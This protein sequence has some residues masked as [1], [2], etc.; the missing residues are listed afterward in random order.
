MVFLP[1]L[2]RPAPV[3]VHVSVASIEA[4]VP[5]KR[6]GSSA[7]AAR[8]V[9]SAHELEMGSALAEF[10]A[11]RLRAEG[12][13]KRPVIVALAPE[14]ISAKIL[15][16]PPLSPRDLHG[17]I[18]RR[19]AAL[20]DLEADEASFSAI[21]LDGEDAADR[22]WLVHATAK[23]P[24]TEFQSTLRSIGYPAKVVIPARTAPFLSSRCT[25]AAIDSG[26]TLVALFERDSCAIGLL[27]EGRIV[28]LSS[29][30]GGIGP[31]LSE[32][33]TARAFVQELRGVDA[34]WRRT[35][36]GDRVGAVLIGGA[37]SLVVEQLG[38]AIR[39]A[40]GDVEVKMLDAAVTSARQEDGALPV[41]SLEA[42]DA[43]NDDGLDPL[44]EATERAR[45]ALLGSLTSNRIGGLDLAVDLRPRGRNVLLVGS[46]SAVVFGTLAATLRMDLE[47]RA[48]QLAVEAQ[49]FEAAAADLEEL[50]GLERSVRGIESQVRTACDELQA[51]SSVGLPAMDLVDGVFGAF[52]GRTELLSISATGPSLAQGGE[53]VLRLRGV[54]EDV[55]GETAASLS[56]LEARLRGVVGVS[57]VEIE[58]PSLSD[59]AGD[60]RGSGRTS[61]RFSAILKLAPAPGAAGSARESAGAQGA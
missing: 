28:H 33:Q 31:H 21:A 44:D 8:L 22:R 13:S 29:L 9:R 3:V 61:L 18:A 37:E 52:D 47:G 58:M 54:V 40:L 24:L 32:P 12:L 6:F 23:K 55:P 50:Q 4:L 30:R 46:A 7:L 19:A 15:E 56:S 27:S 49:V 11:A 45:I 17:V 26:A 38:A 41:A 20:L 10:I 51:A 39:G 48:A 42:L 5:R 43:E 60:L 25:D 36:R 16:L 53:G 57:D 2:R 59:R 35:S 14:L 1:Q 34:F